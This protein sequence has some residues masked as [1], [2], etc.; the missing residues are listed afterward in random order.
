VCGRTPITLVGFRTESGRI[1]VL[2]GECSHLAA[3][4]GR[5]R[6]TG[7]CVQCPFHHW[8]YDVGGKCVRIPAQAEIPVAARQRAYPVIERHGL[9]FFFAGG[10][11]LFPLPFFE[12][13][14][15]SDFVRGR[16]FRF[17]ADFPWYVLVSNAFDDQHFQTVHDRRLLEPAVVD[18][19]SRHARR[20]RYRA[21]IS[22]DSVFDRL[23]RPTVGGTVEI[24]ITSFGGSFVLVTGKF[25]RTTSYIMICPQPHSPDHLA[26]DVIVNPPRSRRPYLCGLGEWL[27]LEVRRLFTRGFMQDDIERLP[28]I[29][30]S[31]HALVESDRQMID[32][33]RW[34][35]GCRRKAM[36]ATTTG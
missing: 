16:P 36:T 30:Y 22:G 12:G 9:L 7:E 21:E 23:L 29:R 13:C 26:V 5:G 25:A 4:L 8:Q 10:V 6:V 17:T 31:R 32:F 34:P 3:N 35:V 24:S 15:P 33:F 14:N 27:S 18:E 2:D 20:I 28:G 11:P 1:A 19:P